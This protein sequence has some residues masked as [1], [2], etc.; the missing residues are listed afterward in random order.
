MREDPDGLLSSAG[1]S[2][3]PALNPAMDGIFLESLNALPGVLENQAMAGGT[4]AIPATLASLKFAAR[5]VNV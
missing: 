3:A 2:R 1:A 4:P 5:L